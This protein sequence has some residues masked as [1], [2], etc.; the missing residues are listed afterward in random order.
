MKLKRLIPLLAV[1]M[2]LAW[3]GCTAPIGADRVT[4]RQ[5]YTQVRANALRTGQPGAATDAILHRYN[6]DGLVARHPDEAVRQL[7]QKALATGERELLFALAEIS[8]V[9]GDRIDRSLK[10]WDPRD[11]RDYYLGSAVYAWL[12]L[13]GEGKE[14]PPGFLDSRVRE[15]C[16]F[17][18]YG[19]GL[20]LTERK[21]TNGVVRVQ[22]GRR[23]LPVGAIELAL[24]LTN[25]T[26][27]PEDFARLAR[28]AEEA[29]R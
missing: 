17:Y 19:L 11:S 9:A 7:H 13:F 12:F 23:Q 29:G 10:P 5:S 16:D 15:A 4:T 6:L 27:R 24:N 14:P 20:A 22:G 26:A 28:R 25:C 1:V 18:N 8:Y 3:G 2:G 21:A